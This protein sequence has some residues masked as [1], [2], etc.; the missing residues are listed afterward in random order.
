MIDVNLIFYLKK[1][2]IQIVILTILLIRIQLK[3]IIYNLL[4]INYNIIY[5]NI[6]IKILSNIRRYLRFLN[7]NFEYVNHISSI[8]AKRLIIL[9]IKLCPK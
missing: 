8:F 4:H 5:K 7:D 9:N 2:Y 1:Y 3:F 6:G